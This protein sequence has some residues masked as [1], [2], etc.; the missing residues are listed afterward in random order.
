MTWHILQAIKLNPPSE[1]LIH[2]YKAGGQGYV[3]LAFK[4]HS[5]SETQIVYIHSCLALFS[6]FH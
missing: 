1:I 2:S 4:K 3:E 6:T 5:Y